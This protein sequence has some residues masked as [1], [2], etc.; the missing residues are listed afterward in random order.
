MTLHDLGL[1]AATRGDLPAALSLFRQALEI[2]RK[3]Y[4]N[5]HPTVAVALKALRTFCVCRGE[6]PRQRRRCRR[7]S[8]SRGRRWGTTISSW[9]FTR[10]TS[11]PYSSPAMTQHRPKRCCGRPADS[12]P[13]ARRR[14]GPPPS[15]PRRRLESR[16]H[17]EP[18][19]RRT[20]GG[21]A[22]RR[23]RGGAPR[24]TPRPPIRAGDARL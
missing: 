23:S 17:Q 15:V 19:W 9:R 20:H 3:A 8:P 7:Q 5:E 10:S 11:R 13:S 1:I 4:G 21:E 24:C 18:A 14:T 12:R 16:R 22:L 2:H 6:T